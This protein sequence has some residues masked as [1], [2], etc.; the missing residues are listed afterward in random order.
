MIIVTMLEFQINNNYQLL[1]ITVVASGMMFIVVGGY[2]EAA[3]ITTE[4]RQ[5]SSGSSWELIMRRVDGWIFVQRL[6][7]NR[8]A[9]SII[10]RLLVGGWLVWFVSCWV[11]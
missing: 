11:L 1:I 8:E 10:N 2:D 3:V 6:T 4:W 9:R 7:S 5:S